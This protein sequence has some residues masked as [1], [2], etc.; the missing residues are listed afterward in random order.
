MSRISKARA[1]AIIHSS[2]IL[3]G[4]IASGT[5]KVPASDAVLTTA[6]VA[7]L[8]IL[9]KEMGLTLSDTVI[10]TFLHQQLAEQMGIHGAKTILRFVPGLGEVVHGS[11]SLV[12][13][14]AICWKFVKKY[15]NA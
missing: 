4:G 7:T 12:T 1:H 9:A 2:A 13:T 3:H 14:E 10:E 15:N 11:V 8:G 6:T 5:A